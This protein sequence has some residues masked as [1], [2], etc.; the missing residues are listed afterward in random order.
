MDK[1]KFNLTNCIY[2]V[3]TRYIE[4]GYNEIPPYSEMF[5]PLIT[6]TRLYRRNI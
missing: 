4:A 5:H 2:T 6:N 3:N 1:A